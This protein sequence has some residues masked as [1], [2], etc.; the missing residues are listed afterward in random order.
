[1]CEIF[2]GRQFF[3]WKNL[4]ITVLKNIIQKVG[5]NLAIQL[6]KFFVIILHDIYGF[7]R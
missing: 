6:A 5:K 1:M 4:V 7:S 3:I 2:L